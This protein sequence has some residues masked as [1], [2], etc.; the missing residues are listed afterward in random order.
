M[1]KDA[2]PLE[3][4]LASVLIPEFILTKGSTLI[5]MICG[6]QKMNAEIMV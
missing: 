5:A 1:T 2:L 6:T 3:N 4:G